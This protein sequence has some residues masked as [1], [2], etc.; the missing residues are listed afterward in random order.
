MTNLQYERLWIYF[1]VYSCLGWILEVT[2]VAMTG[3][4]FTNRG[5]LFGPYC[6]I[7]G[8][9]CL[10]VISITKN[11]IRKPFQFI[12]AS[13]II[14]GILEFSTSVIMEFLFHERWWD[15]SNFFFQ[16]DGRI[17]LET[18]V[19]FAFLSY[20]VTCQMHPLL[21][22]WVFYFRRNTLHTFARY[23]FLLFL[24]DFLTTLWRQLS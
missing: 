14:C 19:P 21:E 12:L 1:W 16:I 5:F 2:F 7:Y 22:K 3:S 6:P 17:C 24:A 4:G 20:L 11:I 13:M 9:G 10:M 15:Y 18:L 8:I 23:T